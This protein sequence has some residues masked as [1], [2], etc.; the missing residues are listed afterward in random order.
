LT[1]KEIAS[2]TPGLV[3]KARNGQLPATELLGATFS[4]SNLGMYGIDSFAAVIHPGQA[5]ILAVGALR[6]CVVVIGGV[7]AVGKLM[8]LT[9]SA[10]HRCIDGAYGAEFMRELKVILETPVRLLV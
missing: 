10:D 8:T 5:A 6:E 2:R 4:I 1:L 7:P 9:L 3:A